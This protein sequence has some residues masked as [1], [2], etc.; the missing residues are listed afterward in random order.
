MNRA[1]RIDN[2]SAGVFNEMEERKRR[3]EAR[4]LEVINIGVGSPDLPPAPHIVEALRRAVEKPRNYT[5]PLVGLRSLREAVAGRYKKRFNVDLDPGSEVLELM[6]SQDGLAHLAMAYIDPG[7]V[8]LV[9]DPGYPIYEFGII[10]AGGEIYPLPLLPENRFLPDFDAIPEEVARRAKMLWLNYPNNPTAAIADS[11]FFERAVAFARRHDILVCHDVAY[12]E[13]AYD[14]FKPVS[15]LE[16]PG[17]KEVGVEFFS[18]SKTY[19]MAGCRLGFAVGNAGVLADL[20]LIKSNI[21]YGVFYAVQEAGVA[22][23]SGPQDCVAATAATYQ[24]R[25]DVLV[26]G[27]AALGWS[28]PKPQASMFVWAPLP[29]GY[30]DSAGFAAELLEKAGVIVIP[31]V[32]FGRRGEG[33]VRIALVK[34]EKVLSEVV[35]RVGENFRFK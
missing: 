33:Y 31:G 14:G 7:D 4:G 18:L 21:D 19:N 17:A 32:A 22:A 26:D 16:T 27:L 6:G 1:K 23:L 25:R 11:E 29:P 15:F 12:A 3:V 13:L 24:G 30:S 8:A 20:A 5:Y 10:L 35:R 2:L 34:E 9:P 28:M